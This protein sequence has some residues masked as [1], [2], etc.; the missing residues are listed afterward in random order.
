MVGLE[1]V[2]IQEVPEKVTRRES[3]S[4]LEV[5]YKNHPL[6]GLRCRHNFAG[7]QLADTL[8]GMRRVL[9]IHSMSAG[10]TSDPSKPECP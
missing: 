2:V 4:S 6:S 9:V 10:V 3:E 7:G 1:L 8:T 5:C